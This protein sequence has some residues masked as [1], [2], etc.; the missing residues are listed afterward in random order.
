MDFT[1]EKDYIMRIIKEMV[2]VLFS[3]M[4]GKQYK[5]VELPEENKYEVSGK[6]L[7]ELEKMVDQGQI[8]E[9]ENM[10]LEHMND[11]EKEDILAAILF[12]QYVGEKDDDFLKRHNYSKEEVLDG[13]KLL[14]EKA[15][16]GGMEEIFSEL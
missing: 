13:L 1:D 6:A 15:G 4:L 3:L 8:N 9:A 2:R 10:L 16:Y 12:Y 14:A 11:A 7:E 5:S